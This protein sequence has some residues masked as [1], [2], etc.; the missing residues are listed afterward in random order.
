VSQYVPPPRVLL[1]V[2]YPDVVGHDVD[3]QAHSAG[4]RGSRQ[5]RQTVG[6]AKLWR[7]RRRVGDVVPMARPVRGGH[8]RRQVEMRHPQ[9]VQIVEQ[10]LGVGEGE[11]KSAGRP[12]EL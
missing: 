4:A 7:H 9:V 1:G 3:D 12:T 2:V 8:D 10:V 6:A 11:A 5:L